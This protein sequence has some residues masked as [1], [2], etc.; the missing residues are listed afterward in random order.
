VAL[1]WWMTHLFWLPPAWVLKLV[2]V[3]AVAIHVFDATLAFRLARNGVAPTLALGWMMQTLVLGWPSL[4]LL[5]R[6]RDLLREGTT[7]K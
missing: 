7:T 6:R 2:F 1:A 3:G 4:R 5:L